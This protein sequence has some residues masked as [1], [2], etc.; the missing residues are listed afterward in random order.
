MKNSLKLLDILA[1]YLISRVLYRTILF[2][3]ILLFTGLSCGRKVDN[4]FILVIADKNSSDII[5]K[6]IDDLAGKVKLKVC[7][8]SSE[9]VEDGAI[10][11]I[12]EKLD[13]KECYQITE[14]D[15]SFVV[16]GG[17]PSGIIYGLTHFL[18]I[19]GFRFPHP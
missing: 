19:A 4:D 2:A 6:F 3:T 9:C 17:F 18:E 7:D 16:K 14:R 15:G 10:N 11:V 1:S 8:E 5:E 12:V 13:C